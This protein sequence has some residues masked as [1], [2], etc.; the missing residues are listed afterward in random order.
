MQSPSKKHKCSVCSR[1]FTRPAEVVRHMRIH[2]GEKPYPC[3]ACGHR[4][5]QK[6]AMKSHYMKIHVHPWG[7][8]EMSL[9]PSSLDVKP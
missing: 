4:F 8:D 9:E 1:G 2:T 3:P 5:N 6:S 7:L